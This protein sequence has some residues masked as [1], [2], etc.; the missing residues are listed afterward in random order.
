MTFLAGVKTVRTQVWTDP[1]DILAAN[2]P[3]PNGS[4]E[5]LRSPGNP[6]IAELWHKTRLKNR[7][8]LS[9]SGAIFTHFYA[10]KIWK[11]VGKLIFRP[12]PTSGANFIKIG[13][14]RRTGPY[15]RLLQSLISGLLRGQI[16][17]TVTPQYDARLRFWWNLHQRWDLA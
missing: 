9:P 14:G 17:E 7:S 12:K 6:Y 16:W 13:V 5:A 4:I 2:S 15:T 1:R 11:M 10:T 8:F 3:G